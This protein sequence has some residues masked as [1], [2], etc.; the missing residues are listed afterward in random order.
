MPA[1]AIHESTV[2]TVAAHRCM[3]ELFPEPLNVTGAA[4]RLVDLTFT[5][6]DVVKVR[7]A[8]L[9]AGLGATLVEAGP[10]ENSFVSRMLAEGVSCLG[11]T[12]SSELAFD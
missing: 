9:T 12:A 7:G 4:G 2:A 11:I 5:V 10:G 3:V 8:R 6:K 1:S